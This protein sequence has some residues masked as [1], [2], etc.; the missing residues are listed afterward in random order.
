MKGLSEARPLLLTVA[1]LA[2]HTMPETSPST[3][4]TSFNPQVIL[5]PYY[6]HFSDDETKAP[7]G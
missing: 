1:R 7:R 4:H 2:E 3:S 6:P 5:G